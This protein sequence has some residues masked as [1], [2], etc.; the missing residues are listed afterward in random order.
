MAVDW[1]EKQVEKL[2]VFAEQN[3]VARHLD[4]F[5]LDVEQNDGAELVQ[6][7][8]SNFDLVTVARFLHRPLIP[9]V[10][11]S[12]VKPGGMVAYHT[13][14]RG[15]EKFG[16]PKNP[17]HLLMLHELSEQFQEIGWEIIAD[18]VEAISDGR[19]C[20]FFIARK[21]LA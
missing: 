9:K 5:C 13:F 7:Y 10:L 17:K 14:M 15:S 12:L 6:K 16:K 2:K 4:A 1:E 18:R 11:A 8:G 3:G 19:P 21:P 20:S